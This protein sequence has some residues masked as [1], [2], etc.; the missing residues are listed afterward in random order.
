MNSIKIIA[1]MFFNRA[2]KLTQWYLL[3]KYEDKTSKFDFSRGRAGFGNCLL[4]FRRLLWTFS[5]ASLVTHNSTALIHCTSGSKFGRKRIINKTKQSLI[6]VYPRQRYKLKGLI[7]ITTVDLRRIV[8]DISKRRVVWWGSLHHS[9]V[10]KFSSVWVS[11]PWE[12]V[13]HWNDYRHSALVFM[14]LGQIKWRVVAKHASR[15]VLRI[16]WQ[17]TVIINLVGIRIF[18]FSV[19][20]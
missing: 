1:I 15:Y 13:Y 3:L 10:H 8:E 4:L 17:S 14:K 12:R 11:E 20:I 16:P 19:V 7:S 5:F 9:W 18:N 2:Y 6:L